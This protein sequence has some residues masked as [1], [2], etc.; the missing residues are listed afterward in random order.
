MNW[1][2]LPPRK[3][4]KYGT[5]L[6]AQDPSPTIIELV[7]NGDALRVV[8]LGRRHLRPELDRE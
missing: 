6:T 1:Q 8:Q 3:T 5:R 7:E 4:G 2:K